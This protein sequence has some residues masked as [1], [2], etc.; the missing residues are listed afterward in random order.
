VVAFRE[1][2][3]TANPDATCDG[4]AALGY[5]TARLM[6]RA[7]EESKTAEPA[8]IRQALSQTK[9]FEGVTGTITY[10]GGSRIPTKSVSLV[11]VRDGKQRLVREITPKNVPAP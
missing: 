2:F 9:N 1:A 4:F 10:A 7:V 5:D 3:L 8:A 11:G 6:M